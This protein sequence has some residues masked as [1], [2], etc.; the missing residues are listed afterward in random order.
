[1]N[2]VQVHKSVYRITALFEPNGGTV[3]PYLI[4]GDRIVMVDTGAA[5]T[6]KEILEPAM[7]EI[8]LALSD[9]EVILNTHSHLDHAG[10]NLAV[11]QASEASIHVH[12]GD[13]PMANSTE[14]QVEWMTAPLRA[15]NLPEAVRQRTEY[16]IRNAG[17]PAGADVVLSEGDVV[18][19]GA[20][21]QLRVIHLPGHTPG[22]I[23]YYWESEGM[24][25]TGDAAQGH[26]ARPGGY[27]LYF[28]A[29]EY[30]R[31]L[32]TLAGIDMN[33]LC[34]GHSYFGGGALND[35]TRRGEACQP[36]LR[37]SMRLADAFH[38]AAA[39][40]VRQM[41]ETSKLEIAR[42]ALSELIYVSPQLWAR[43]TRMPTQSGPTLLA[44][45][46]AVLDGSYPA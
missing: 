38:R 42:A 27:P 37:E 14:V 20:G 11:K 39:E 6:P 45:I 29:S 19:L 4:K 33:V 23:G 13:L 7:A 8:G 21:I 46:D 34:L 31:S 12:S 44:H 24:I 43:D 10:G 22:S 41:P 26:G 3:F 16:V 28:N 32:E 17:E 18:E 30:R 15:L 5:H 1:M 2:L 9:V 35:P 40:A 25:F 36:F